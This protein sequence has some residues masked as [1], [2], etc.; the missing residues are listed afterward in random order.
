METSDYI[1]DTVSYVIGDGIITY[2]K[3]GSSVCSV[4]FSY[5]G[6][7]PIYPFVRANAGCVAAT[8][9]GDGY[10][11]STAVS[12]GNADEAGYGI[13]EYAPPSGFYSL[14]SKNINTYG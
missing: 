1:D 8:N 5:D 13:F 12:S 7:N 2:Y 6:E 10:F 4:T 11:G 3:N 9:M 14:C